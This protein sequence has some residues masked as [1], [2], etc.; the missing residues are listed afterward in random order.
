M[1]YTRHDCRGGVLRVQLR[2]DPSLFTEPQTVAARIGGED[3]G[4]VTFR[5]NEEREL[6]VTLRPRD[7]NCVVVFSV[8]PTRVPAEVS[9]ANSDTRELGVHFDR[10]HYVGP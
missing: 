3:A 2:G 7:G 1:T 10:F 9:R 4:R 5:P 6:A 8:S